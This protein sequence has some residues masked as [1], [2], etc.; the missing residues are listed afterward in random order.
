MKEH[1]HS[2]WAQLECTG[3]LSWDR[4]Q[5]SDTEEEENI[6]KAQEQ[7][8]SLQAPHIPKKKKR[9]QHHARL[10]VGITSKE[11][12]AVSASGDNIH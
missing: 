4:I 11:R 8:C 9:W 6:M 3:E 2:Q 7:R 12:W 1:P 5:S 10:F